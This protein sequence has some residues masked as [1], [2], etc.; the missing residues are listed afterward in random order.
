MNLHENKEKAKIIKTTD[1]PLP[2]SLLKPA[3]KAFLDF[4]AV[5]LKDE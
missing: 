2:F 1:C 3:V 4:S 5:I